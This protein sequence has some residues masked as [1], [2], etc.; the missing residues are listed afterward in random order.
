MSLNKIARE[1]DYRDVAHLEMNLDGD[2]E[3]SKYWGIIKELYSEASEYYE[4]A[5]N[6]CRGLAHDE[7]NEI[8]DKYEKG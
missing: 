1:L 6:N 4:L 5:Y 8:V 2:M 3:L 7:L